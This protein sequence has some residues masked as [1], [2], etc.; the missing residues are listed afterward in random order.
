MISPE[1]LRELYDYNYW[2][3]GKQL[4]ACAALSEEQFLRP[5]GSS[6]SSVRDTLA[7]MMGAEW[8]WLER[9]LGRPARTL[10]DVPEGLPFAE[11]LKRWHEQFPNVGQIRKRWCEIETEMRQYL[12]G[13]DERTLSSDFSYVNLQ[14]RTWTYPL[15]RSIYHLANHG[16]FHRGQITTLLRQLGAS[17]PTIDYLVMQDEGLLR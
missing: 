7:H 12:S 4:D 5:M 13:L 1:M 6:F 9:W 14:G 15:W 2:A 11:T 3:K 17:A 10:P 8:I 16:T